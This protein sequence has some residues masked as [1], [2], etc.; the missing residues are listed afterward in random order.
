MT[1]VVPA[2]PERDGWRDESV[3]VVTPHRTE[4][5]AT[6]TSSL[7]KMFAHDVNSTRMVVRGGGPLLF[8]ASVMRL[9]EIRNQLAA[10][11]LDQTEADWLLM[12]DADAG[13]SPDLAERLVQAADPVERPIVGALAFCIEKRESDDMSGFVWAP[14]PTIYDWGGPDGKPGFFHRWDYPENTLV[15][16]QATGAHALLVHRSVLEKL[17]AEG[18]VWFSRVMLDP[19]QGVLGEDFSFCARAGRAGFPVYVHTGIKTTH[20]ASIWLAEQNYQGA[21]LVSRLSAVAKA[22]AQAA[23]EG[24]S[25]G[26]E[27]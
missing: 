27:G 7:L 4:V 1:T 16:C 24:V 17:R 14:A 23:V 21:L 2:P 6:F 26:P 13:F 20:V 10:V 18:D 19:T 3:L 5:A 12:V 8:P 15:R 25:G 11:M 22:E 9:P